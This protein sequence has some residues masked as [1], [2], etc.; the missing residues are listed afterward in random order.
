LFAISR[1]PMLSAYETIR[2]Y[3][4]AEKAGLAEASKKIEALTNQA[5]NAK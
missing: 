2:R 3:D 1:G 5:G 4:L